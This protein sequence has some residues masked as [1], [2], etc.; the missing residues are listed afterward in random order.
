MIDVTQMG[1][2]GNPVM[3]VAL[4]LPMA[5]LA[6]GAYRAE[7]KAA[8]TTGRSVTRAVMFEVD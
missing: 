4:K 2:M 8:D 5:E 1:K 6:P 7:F 3:P